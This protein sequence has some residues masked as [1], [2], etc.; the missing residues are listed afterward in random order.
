M[1]PVTVAGRD[2]LASAGEDRTVQI[3]DP[4]TTGFLLT[5]PVHHEALAAARV[6]GSL[7]IG[8]SA[9]I[10]VIELSPAL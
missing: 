5:I 1:R 7:A 10:L 3:W 9:G 4:A 2:L 8:L 6:S